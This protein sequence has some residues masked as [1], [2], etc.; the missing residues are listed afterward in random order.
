MLWG[1]F[2]HVVLRV[3][4]FAPA[5]APTHAPTLCSCDMVCLSLTLEYLH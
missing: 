5:P 2:N 4:V 3:V 1:P